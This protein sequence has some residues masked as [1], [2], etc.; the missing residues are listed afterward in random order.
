MINDFWI[1]D[2]INLKKI[3]FQRNHTI[4]HTGNEPMALL[5]CY[6]KEVIAIGRQDLEIQHLSKATWKIRSKQQPSI[7]SNLLKFNLWGYRTIVY[8]LCN[9]NMQNSMKIIWTCEGVHGERF[10][11]IVIPSNLDIKIVIL[12]ET[13]LNIRRRPYKEYIFI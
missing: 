7:D 1:M 11:D 4:C 6:L 12:F 8:S 3:Y 13:A 10:A 9:L 2:G 5:P